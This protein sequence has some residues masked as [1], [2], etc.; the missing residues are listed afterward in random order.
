VPIRIPPL[1]VWA[2]RPWFLLFAEPDIHWLP[3][4]SWGLC[5]RLSVCSLPVP[6][7]LGGKPQEIALLCSVGNRQDLAACALWNSAFLVVVGLGDR[8]AMILCGYKRPLL[9]IDR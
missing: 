1:A 5:R 4:A 7:Q 6:K 9:T 3:R 2:S 8:C